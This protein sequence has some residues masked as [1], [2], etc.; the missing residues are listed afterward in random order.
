MS[1]GAVA[2]EAAAGTVAEAVVIAATAAVVVE[3]TQA[4][5][6]MFIVLFFERSQSLEM[7]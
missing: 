1:A 5:K 3:S 4:M 6:S 7:S 2:G